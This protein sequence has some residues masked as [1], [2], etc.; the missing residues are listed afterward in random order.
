[1]VLCFEIKSDDLRNV[2]KISTKYFRS[3]NFVLIFAPEHKSHNK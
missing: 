1:M 3:L 2:V